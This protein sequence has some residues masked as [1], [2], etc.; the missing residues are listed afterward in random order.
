MATILVA[1]IIRVEAANCH[2]FSAQVQI[3]SGEQGGW[4]L[5]QPQVSR[6]DLQGGGVKWRS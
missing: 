5:E 2:L 4:P 1:C 6:C 3:S